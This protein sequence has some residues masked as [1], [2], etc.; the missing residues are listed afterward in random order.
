MVGDDR[1]SRARPGGTLPQHTRSHVRRGK[2]TLALVALVAAA[3][4]APPTSAQQPE[5]DAAPVPIVD[6]HPTEE[7]VVIGPPHPES[8]TEAGERPLFQLPFRWDETWQA[9]SP[10]ADGSS[11]LDFGPRRSGGNDD[12]VAAAAGTVQRVRC[13]GGSYPRVDHGGGWVTHY[14]HVVDV[15]WGLVGQRVLAGTRLGDAGNATPCGGRSTFPHVHWYVEHFGR[16]V[17]ADGISI[18]GYT[19]H[20]GGRDYYGHWTDDGNGRTVVTNPGEAQ[21]CLRSTTRPFHV[22]DRGVLADLDGDGRDDVVLRRN[23][24]LSISTDSSVRGG[25]PGPERQLTWGRNTDQVHLGDVTGDGR[26]DIVFR[27]GAQYY[28]NHDFFRAGGD[29]HSDHRFTWGRSTD[30]LHLADVSG[31]GREDFI[32]RNGS[33]I[34]ISTDT[35]AAGGDPGAEH[36]LTFG[37]GGDRLHLGDVTGDGRADLVIRRGAQHFV[38]HDA[39]APGGDPEVDRQFT[40]GAA[41]GRL[42]LGDVTG[43][44]RD[45]F[46]LRD[47]TAVSVSTDSVVDGGDHT[48]EHRFT[49]GRA[50]DLLFLGDVTGDGTDDVVLRR[51]RD[52]FVNDDALRDGGDAA[53]DRSFVAGQRTDQ[54]LVQPT[55]TT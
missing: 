5:G 14:Y 24:T 27:R 15:N 17:S 6:D 1:R 29:R 43:D 40:W 7:G 55:D 42:H 51:G 37:A 16:R 18:A 38:E 28:V 23:T 2:G 44:G 13:S 50:A 20:S 3:W 49:W 34:A 31:D 39:L 19:V 4:T 10:H 45:D 54:L 8:G 36:R 52:Y 41:G 12:V 46:V 30:R 35:V 26:A 48:T 22:P 21:C 25:D 47:G 11:A 53:G 33:T 9:G 32:L